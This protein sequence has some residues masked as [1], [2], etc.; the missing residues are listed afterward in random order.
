MRVS[1]YHAGA[2]KNRMEKNEIMFPKIA[3]QDSVY[4][5]TFLAGDLVET[6]CKTMS[7][8]DLRNMVNYIIDNLPQAYN[9]LERGNT[10]NLHH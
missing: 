8:K 2:R 9:K 10:E 1:A 4:S 3:Y 7:Y 6:M 5:Q